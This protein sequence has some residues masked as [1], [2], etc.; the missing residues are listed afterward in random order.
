[1][2]AGVLPLAGEGLSP[3]G[4]TGSAIYHRPQGA[5]SGHRARLPLGSGGA[6]RAEQEWRQRCWQISSAWT[7]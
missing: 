5:I 1:M 2:A 4:R 3:L 7:G 6:G